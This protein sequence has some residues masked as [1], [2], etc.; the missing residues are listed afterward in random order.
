MTDQEAEQL[1]KTTVER[2]C[3]AFERFA[4]A[5]EGVQRALEAIARERTQ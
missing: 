4:A 1:L 5:H 2:L 3:A